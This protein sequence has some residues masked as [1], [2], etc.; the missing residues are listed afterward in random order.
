MSPQNIGDA[1]S[2]AKKHQLI[3][4]CDNTFASPALCRPLV[5]GVDLVIESATKYLN[6][7]SDVIAGMIAG[8]HDLINQL[9]PPH[10]Y[11]GTFLPTTQCVML[12]RGL[13]T[14]ELRMKRHSDNGAL[15]AEALK[16][17]PDVV[18]E[19]SYGGAQSAMLSSYFPLGFGGMVSVRFAPHVHVKKLMDRM[20]L[21][22]N[23]PSLGGT[24]SNAT[25][26]SY[27]TN[28][29][30]SPEEKA[31]YRI[32]DQL[33][34]FSVGLERVEDLIDDVLTAAMSCS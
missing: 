12:L 6:G 11:L 22:T 7:H 31:R 32:D 28:W 26:P 16:A 1:V 14:L 23:A 29:F 18:A 8:R 13:K 34:R 10:A 20:S 5:H 15:F 33:V 27:S 25:M 17:R 24:E 3:S 2:F 4:V 19:V 9:R 30:M 21:V